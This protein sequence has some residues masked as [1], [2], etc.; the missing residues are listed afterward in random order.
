ML[1]VVKN[2]IKCGVF[3]LLCPHRCRGC[4]EL[5]SVLC[6]CCKNYII[7]SRANICPKCGQPIGYNCLSCH[8]PFSMVFCL[9]FRD[10]TVGEMAEEY[11]FFGVRAIGDVVAEIIDERIPGVLG[12]VR[13]V[14]IPT[15]QRHVRERG[16]DHTYQIAKKL[17]KRRGWKVSQVLERAKNTV[18]IG[19][20]AKTRLQQAKEAFRLSEKVRVDSDAT[21]ILFDDVWTT[22]ASMIQAGKILREAG[23]RNLI[24]VVVVKASRPKNNGKI[25]EKLD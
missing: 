17:A 3:D 13:I 15:I 8:L 4:G 2:T 20:D 22:G 23:A 25:R 16:V 19:K 24:A 21:Y 12:D 18:Q 5:G 9:G 7:S 6:R 10:E 11:K 1:N 14:P